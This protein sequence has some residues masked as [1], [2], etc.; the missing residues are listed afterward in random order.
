MVSIRPDF[1]W[2]CKK[3]IRYFNPLGLPDGITQSKNFYVTANPS[4]YIQ[5]RLFSREPEFPTGF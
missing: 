4:V 3:S 2:L 1:R 5:K